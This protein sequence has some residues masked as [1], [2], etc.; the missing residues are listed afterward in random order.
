VPWPAAPI[1]SLGERARRSPRHK[2]LHT[3]PKEVVAQRC[4][5]HRPARRWRERRLPIWKD[6]GQEQRSICDRSDREQGAAQPCGLL[7]V[8]TFTPPA[9]CD[10][11]RHHPSGRNQRGS[12]MRTA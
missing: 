3:G 8:A 10:S 11:R 1:L 12:I 5:E 2:I 4:P 7:A 6:P 9:T